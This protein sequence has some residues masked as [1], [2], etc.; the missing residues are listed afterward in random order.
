MKQNALIY[1][2]CSCFFSFA[3]EEKQIKDAPLQNFN[4]SG[5]YRF[6][7]QHRIFNDPYII[8]TDNGNTQTIN[9]R[10]IL[11]GDASQL[12]ELTLNIS[13][14]PTN[15]VAFGTDLV[16]W[17]QNNGNFDYYR[18]L[19]LGINLYGSFKTKKTSV[20]IRTGGIF[21]HEISPLTFGSFYG[22]NRFSVF[23]RNPWDPQT[24][25]V[26]DRYSNYYEE[27]NI[28]QDTRWANQAIQGIIIDSEFPKRINLNLIYGRAQNTGSNFLN[29]SFISNTN[30]Y[31]NT[32]PNYVFGGALS[33]EFKSFKAAINNYNRIS[34]SDT[35]A[36]KSITNHIVTSSVDYNS[37]KLSFS[38]EIGIGKYEDEFTPENIGWGELASIKVNTNKELTFLP[39]QIHTYRISE[40]VVN[41]NSIFI[42]SSI[43]QVQSAA[44]SG[45][46]SVAS[47]GVL[48]QTGSGILPMGQLANNRQG[49]DLSTNFKFKSFQFTIGNSIAKEIKKIGNQISYNHLNGLT[50]SRFWR[51]S[52][53]SGVGPYQK[54]NVVYRSVYESI[55]LTQTDNNGNLPFHKFFNTA[56]L[57]LKYKL[58]LFKKQM[59]FFYLSSF[60][61]VQDKLSAFTIIN[62]KAFLRV[63][64][65][66]IENYYQINKNIILTQYV[67]IERIVG[68][69]NT[70]LN[71]E[72]GKPVNQEGISIGTGFD[73]N[74]AKNTGLY[75]RH[76]YFRFEDASF[77]LDK[78]SGHETTLELK[79][80]F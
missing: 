52:F 75:F 80:V 61:S 54:K 77:P 55:I 41:N 72:T 64:N 62:E 12:P 40:K 39:L 57:Q 4:I 44:S 19:Q 79:V 32:I 5:N 59:Y 71:T 78:F 34:F 65:H 10:S 16:V 2:I 1:L 7:A 26:A 30:M 11:I 66:Q 31:Q 27:G 14:N 29:P 68:N 37:K 21:W 67:G 6:Y 56:E 45:P 22:Y 42:N 43:N 35:L 48:Q 50:M 24:R 51:W 69:Y 36:L 8:G 28:N 25:N 73:F 47:N 53:P 15:K 58:N 46:S 18:S 49:F 23:E 63:Y 20:N 38:S 76:R 70:Q 13:G 17:N 3:Q 60:N 74:I 9:G 33:K